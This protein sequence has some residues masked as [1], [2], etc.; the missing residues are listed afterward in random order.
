MDKNSSNSSSGRRQIAYIGMLGTTHIHLRNPYVIAWWSAAFPGLGHL[1]L[2]KHLRGFLLFIW[3]V[4]VN[5]N[6]HINLA[7]LYTFTGRF[8]MAKQVINYNWMMLYCAVYVFSI[9]DAYRTAI[10]I[11]NNYILAARE[12]AEI[13]PFRM[14]AMEINYLDRRTPWVSALW[15]LLV[16]GA[17]QLYIHRIVAA[18]FILTYWMVTIYFSRV[19]PAIH[20]T[21]TGAFEQAKAVLDPHWTLNISSVYLFAMYDAYINTV[22]NNNLFDW[23]QSKFLKKD[24]QDINFNIPSKRKAGRGDRMHIISIFEH[25]IYLEKAI[26]AVQMMGVAKEDILAVSM[27]KRGAERKLFD[28]MHQSDGLSLIDLASILGTIFMLLGTIY[29]FVLKYGPIFW[30]LVGLVTGSILGFIIKLITTKKYSDRQKYKRMP[31]VVL[32]IECKEDKL[33]MVKDTL[34]SNHALGV[35]KLSLGNNE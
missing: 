18:A 14:Y 10:D 6:A 22:E 3:E 26:T 32:I 13:K 34:W 20:L 11:N 33:D 29:G 23:E 35:S 30:G 17:G 5:I 16:P 19:L 4:V 24:Y 28:S 15:S 2:S 9:Y 7:V 8:E 1:L 31:E 27:D 25:S 12:D 21:F